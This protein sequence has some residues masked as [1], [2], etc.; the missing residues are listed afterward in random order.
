MRTPKKYQ[1]LDEYRAKLPKLTKSQERWFLDN[2]FNNFAFMPGAKY[3]YC[4]KCNQKYVSSINEKV[5]V[6]PHCGEKIEVQRKGRK[7]YSR[8]L[9]ATTYKGWQ[10]FRMFDVFIKKD[11][12]G[13]HKT[14]FEVSQRWVDASGNSAVFA[15]SFRMFSSELNYDSEIVYKKDYQYSTYYVSCNYY[16]WYD[17]MYPR[18]RFIPELKRNGIDMWDRDNVISA[19][20]NILQ[21]PL[22]ESLVKNGQSEIADYIIKDNYP[23]IPEHCVKLALRYSYKP[24]VKTWV[25]YIRD[26][27]DLNMDTHNPKILLP[28]NLYEAHQRTIEIKEKR[29]EEREKRNKYISSL[30]TAKSKNNLY[31]KEKK[32]YLNITFN[33]GM[34]FFHVL[35]N[36]NEF[37][38]EGKAM[39]HCVSS[40]WD[41]QDSLVLSARDNTGKRVETVEVD[42]RYYKVVQSR[43]VCNK[44]S[45]HH[46]RIV[47]M[48]E[49][50]MNLF[51]IDRKKLKK[52]RKSVVL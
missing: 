32:D 22:I 24:D 1:V 31:K 35:Q 20:I 36:V 7:F 49:N 26:L 9:I 51:K 12:D 17:E 45:E 16:Y 23:R 38:E 52:A 10:V 30:K 13:I 19:S 25:D 5:E 18:K 21:K 46:Q 4:G 37:F 15:R 42:L 6:C 41:K 14:I 40:Y 50:N 48:V 8:V 29:R 47:K 11:K 43:G 28:E 3:A 2:A 44:D 34:I 27:Q 39:H 33:D